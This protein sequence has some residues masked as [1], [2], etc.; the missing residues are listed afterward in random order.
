MASETS[1]YTSE[2]AAQA[3]CDVT[4]VLV[5]RICYHEV[6][7]ITSMLYTNRAKSNTTNKTE[8]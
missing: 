4:Q 1:R 5:D 8:Q 6:A 3:M 7:A 2:W